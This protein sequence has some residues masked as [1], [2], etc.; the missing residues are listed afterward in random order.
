MRLYHFIIIFLIAGFAF[1]TYQDSKF[2][3]TED[4]Q[5]VITQFG[6]VVGEA[7]TVPGEH[8]KTPFIQKTHYFKKN[9]YISESRQQIPTLDK[10]FIWV[11]SKSVWK[12]SDPVTYYRNIN[13][14]KLAKQILFD[15][16]GSSE[17]NIIT[18]YKLSDIIKSKE[19]QNFKDLECKANIQYEIKETAKPI[20]A[21]KGLA[22]LSVEVK[23][24]YIKDL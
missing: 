7:I 3:V 23:I 18:S 2:I 14:T 24:S 4:D 12:I 11:S 5:V 19:Q 10:K 16:V 8:F 17:R 15:V 20:I 6:K 9:F 1:V 22:L 21:E 13:S